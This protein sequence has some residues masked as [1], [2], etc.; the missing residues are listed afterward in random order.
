MLILK[1]L[2]SRSCV[3]QTHLNHW[4]DALWHQS[5][6]QSS[7]SPCVGKLA[8]RVVIQIKTWK[9]RN[10]IFARFEI[11][12]SHI[13]T[14]DLSIHFNIWIQHLR[15]NIPHNRPSWCLVAC[16]NSEISACCL[17]IFAWSRR[18]EK[19]TNQ[20]T[21]HMNQQLLIYIFKE[22]MG[23]CINTVYSH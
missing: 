21:Y 18:C 8:N 16:F 5:L 3:S 7:L 23:N 9:L 4:C 22:H 12:N 20:Y 6:Y 10:I 15:T 13:S 17:M 19:C 14:K 2:F 11:F 1:V